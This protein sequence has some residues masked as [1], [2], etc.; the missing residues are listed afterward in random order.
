M[1]L[2]IKGKLFEKHQLEKYSRQKVL[3]ILAV[4]IIF[5]KEEIVMDK[6]NKIK[7]IIKYI[8]LIVIILIMII[9]NIKII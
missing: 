3:Q 6:I 9:K 5:N 4:I 7:L 2:I 8:K 1:N